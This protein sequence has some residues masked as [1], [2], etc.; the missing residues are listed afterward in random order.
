[1][2]ARLLA[3]TDRQ[4]LSGLIVFVL[5]A[6]LAY[7]WNLRPAQ[8]E[9]GD[10]PQ[11]LAAGYHLLHQHTF[12]EDPAANAAASSL[13]REPGYG[14]FLAGLMALDPGMRTF[15]PECLNKEHVCPDATYRAAKWA[16]IFFVFVSVFLLY[17]TI[18]LTGGLPLAGLGAALCILVNHDALKMRNGVMSDYLA[19]FLVACVLLASAAV[20]KKPGQTGRW[21]GAGLALA[22]LTLTKAVFLFFAVMAFVVCFIGIVTRGK[23]TRKTCLIG[24][25]VFGLS[26]ALPV[27]GWM[28]RNAAIGGNVSLAQSRGGI[29][30]STREVFNHM[31]PRQYLCAFVYWTR[32]F[33]DDLA[34]RLFP[35]DVWQPFQIE[36]KGAFYDYGQNRYAPRV[37]VLMNERRL[38]RPAAERL[39]DKEMADAIL[40][41]PFMHILT[42]L[43]LFYRGIW[44]DE[45][46]VLTLPALFWM[47]CMAFRRRRFDRLALVSLGWFNLLFYALVSL[48]VPRY[49][50]TAVPVLA[51]CGG[52]AL[53]ALLRWRTRKTC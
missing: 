46:I 36:R 16:N 33:G 24:L 43:P 1:M 39:V 20:F 50:L 17:G 25:V 15:T 14:F 32:G 7:G 48:N 28:A 13:G 34:K 9:D 8:P 31:S 19:F 35:P 47:T 18:R 10:A 45:A 40:E 3:L 29:A 41:R 6:V 30:L 5:M 21:L 2:T 4:A 11:Y 42:T 51:L 26:Y 37:E 23:A 38:T 49:Q 53:E 12:S 22:A 44:I 27:G 52:F